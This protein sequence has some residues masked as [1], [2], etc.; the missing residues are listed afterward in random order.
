MPTALKKSECKGNIMSFPRLIIANWDLPVSRSDNYF[1]SKLFTMIRHEYTDINSICIFHPIPMYVISD[2]RKGIHQSRPPTSQSVFMM[3][4]LKCM[5]CVTKNK[6]LNIV[7]WMF[8][9]V[10]LSANRFLSYS[11]RQFIMVQLMTSILELCDL[12][13]LYASTTAHEGN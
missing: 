2:N 11:H 6:L 7:L 10:E 8:L 5:D 1:L 9:V 3:Q 4:L 13:P 12:M